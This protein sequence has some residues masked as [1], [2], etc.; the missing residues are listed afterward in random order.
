MTDKL[1]RLIE[2]ARAYE[3]SPE[4]RHEQRI[5]LAWGNRPAELA[6]EP[7]EKMYATDEIRRSPGGWDGKLS[8][9]P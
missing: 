3:M 8:S 2:K 6:D 4:E 1:D 9:L 5:S 7:I